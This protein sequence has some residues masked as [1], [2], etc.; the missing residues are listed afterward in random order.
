MVLFMLV[1]LV[2]VMYVVLHWCCYFSH[3]HAIILFVGSSIEWPNPVLIVDFFVLVLLLFPWL[4]W[5]FAPFT[6]CRLECWSLETKNSSIKGESFHF[7]HFVLLFKYFIYF[8]FVILKKIS[9]VF[10][11][12]IFL[13]ISLQNS[14]TSCIVNF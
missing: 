8:K 2:L 4:V 7:F 5:Y 6:M 12:F 14:I 10:L 3:I 11:I 13:Y 9:K 1:H